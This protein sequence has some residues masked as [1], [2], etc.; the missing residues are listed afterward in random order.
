[1]IMFDDMFDFIHHADVIILSHK[2]LYQ[3]IS[4]RKEISRGEILHKYTCL[5]NYNN[6]LACKH[7]KAFFEH[8]TYFLVVFSIV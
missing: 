6:V 7:Y 8:Y 1:M 4:Y 5:L 3:K 2:S